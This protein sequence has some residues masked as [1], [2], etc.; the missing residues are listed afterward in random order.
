M[1]ASSCNESVPPSPA[2]AVF[3]ECRTPSPFC[4]GVGRHAC[5]ESLLPPVGVLCVEMKLLCMEVYFLGNLQSR[6]H[7]AIF[8]YMAIEIVTL[9]GGLVC[10]ADMVIEIV[11]LQGWTVAC[12]C[13]HTLLFALAIY[14]YDFN[15]RQVLEVIAALHS[16]NL[17]ELSEKIY[18]N[19]CTLFGWE[20]I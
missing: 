14:N 1:S 16:I 17:L 4:Y 12:R 13:S 20:L 6:T 7:T 9:Q 15:S 10:L 8:A 2:E 3:Y 19:T 18:H 5:F 11:T